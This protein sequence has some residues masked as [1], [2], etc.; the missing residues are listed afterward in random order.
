MPGPLDYY[1]YTFVAY[2]KDNDTREVD[3]S[4][5]M[6]NSNNWSPLVLSY[7]NEEQ[8]EKYGCKICM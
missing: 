3:V 5:L 4:E 8:F 7:A 6:D 1:L 2:Y